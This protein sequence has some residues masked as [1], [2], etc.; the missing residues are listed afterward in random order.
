MVGKKSDSASRWFSVFILLAVLVVGSVPQAGSAQISIRFFPQTGKTVR[1]PFLKYWDEHGGLAQQG[2]PISEEMWERS[3]VDGKEYVVQYFER[4]V[5]EHHPENAETPY[6]VLLA[7]VGKVRY[8]ERY[9]DGAPNQE[10]NYEV[11]SILFSQ[12]SKRLGGRFLDYWREHGG[13]LQQGFPISDEFVEQSAVNGK[14]YRVQYFER[15][16]FEYHPEERPPYDVLLSQLGSYRY[17]AS[18]LT[19]ANGSALLEKAKEA[20]PQRYLYAVQQGA[21][22]EL[23]PDGRSFYLLWYPRGGGARST[24]MIVT[25]HGSSSWAFDEFYAWHSY[26]NERG[27]AILALQ[28][29]FGAG[30]NYSDYYTPEELHSTLQSVL[31]EKKVQP[32]SAIL[33]GFS[34]GSANSYGVTY[35]DRKAGRGFFRFTIANAGG[36]MPDFPINAQITEDLSVRAPFEGTRWVMFC[37]GQDPKPERTGCPAMRRSE[38]WVSNLGGEVLR[39][40]EDP[41]GGHSSFRQNAE[42]TRAALDVIDKDW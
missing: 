25:L 29:W 1:N 24:R 8:K 9:P 12:T 41:E 17:K 18:Y 42:N 34:R 39:F 11:G 38:Q 5:F 23:T 22:I 26:A 10:P 21:S 31:E 7:L 32:G 2:Y 15:A 4:A 16:V 33:H 19:P 13:L 36:A 37:G 28:W 6:E 40:I 27:Y 20:N 3:E 35:L 14:I 30:E